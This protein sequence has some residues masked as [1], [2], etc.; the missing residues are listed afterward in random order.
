MRIAIDANEAN[1]GNKVG[2]NTYAFNI[3]WELYKLRDTKNSEIEFVVYLKD[4]PRSDLPKKDTN[5]KYQIL[6]GGGFWILTKLMPHLLLT[7]QKPDIL[8]SPSHYTVP[9]LQ[10]PRVCSIMDLGYLEFSGQFQ[11]KVFWQL[12]YWTAI[13]ILASKKVIAIS[14]ATAKDIVRQYPSASN[15]VVVTYLGYD[16]NKYNDEVNINDVRQIKHK[17]S[18]EN[19]YMLFLSTLKP[20]KNIEGNI[21]AFS[22]VCDNYPNLQLVIA[23]KKGWLYDEIFELTKKLDLTRKVIFTDYVDED[24]K[25]PL[26][27][28][29]I[30]FLS[31]SFWEGFGLHVLE[32]MACGTPVI[33]SDRGSLPEI[34]GDLGIVV[35][36][37]NV[38]SIK[39]GMEKLLGMDKKSYNMLKVRSIK[40]AKEFDWGKT[41]EETLDLLMNIAK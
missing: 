19:D 23:G 17:Y 34:V 40:K 33:V 29:A 28:G 37:D 12:K 30:G 1:V 31:P 25:K 14:K 24:D 2:V 16:R 11:K 13:S 3:L 9:I 7:R 6:P 41:G 5:W 20:S 39:N 26:I 32:S 18:I 4:K 10:V 15:K 35:D 8:F 21:N 36:P 27:Q 22:L 38:G